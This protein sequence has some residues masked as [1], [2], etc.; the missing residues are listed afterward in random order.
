MTYLFFDTETTGLPNK[1]SDITDVSQPHVIQLAAMMTDEVGK[2]LSSIRLIVRMPQKTDTIPEAASAVHGISTEMTQRYGVR[3]LA[4]AIMFHDMMVCSKTIVAH[5]LQ[6]DVSLMKILYA[7]LERPQWFVER[8]QVCTMRQAAP[9][10][11]LPPT[12]R[13]LAAGFNKPKAPSLAECYKYFFNETL[14]GAHDAMVDVRACA[15]VF[16]HMK[17]LAENN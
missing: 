2:E 12:E 8:A 10:V 4:A 11:N 9:I 1:R 14:E 13:M 15:R 7:R 3:P 5:N 17:G 6:F 16:F